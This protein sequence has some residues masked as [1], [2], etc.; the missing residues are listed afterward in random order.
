MLTQATPA[1]ASAHCQPWCTDHANGTPPGIRPAVEDQLCRN[2][3]ASP[4]FG[5]FLMTS[6][7]DDGPMVLLFNTHDELTLAE[8]EQLAYALLATVA[9]ARSA[10]AT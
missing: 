8:V 1:T 5:E 6:C 3:V 2:V 9:G 10:V 7:I 4:A